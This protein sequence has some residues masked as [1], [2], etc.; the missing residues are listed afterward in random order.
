[1]ITHFKYTLHKTHTLTWNSSMIKSPTTTKHK[2]FTKS[3][4]VN[5]E[6]QSTIKPN[7][8]PKSKL[9]PLPQFKE[10]VSVLFTKGF[11][12][13]TLNAIHLGFDQLQ[14]LC[15]ATDIPPIDQNSENDAISF[16]RFKE[17]RYLT[18]LEQFIY[19]FPSGTKFLDSYD[20]N[21]GRF[22]IRFAILL[23]TVKLIPKSSH[24]TQIIELNAEITGYV[25]SVLQNISISPQILDIVSQVID[26]DSLIKASI[27]VLE[28]FIKTLDTQFKVSY[29]LYKS[30]LQK[31]SLIFEFNIQDN[32]YL[33][34]RY[35]LTLNVQALL[36]ST[37]INKYLDL[38]Y[39]L[40]LLLFELGG[41]YHPYFQQHPQIIKPL[42]NE[43]QKN[44]YDI[45]LFE[46]KNSFILLT[47]VLGLKNFRQSPTDLFHFLPIETLLVNKKPQ[48]FFTN[49]PSRLDAST[50]MSNNTFSL[51]LTYLNSVTQL[52]QLE[53][54]RLYTKPSYPPIPFPPAINQNQVPMN[55]SNV[56]NNFNPQRRK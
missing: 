12:D 27:P 11:A 17:M 6:Q 55:Q 10:D 25:Q 46:I 32:R 5:N 13:V 51:L 44:Q 7:I 48:E 49:K 16:Y 18:K 41:L 14:D 4:G 26:D 33:D 56:P 28:N 47:Y 2:P 45:Y 1:M 31:I 24:S 29:K 3:S 52:L 35:L 22:I 42:L 15:D 53:I 40:V 23:Q 9:T 43:I 50:S 34:A 21:K 38:H 19:L 30:I 36:D 54:V 37:P 20:R 8:I 39:L